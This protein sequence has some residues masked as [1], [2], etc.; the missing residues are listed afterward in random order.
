M[1]IEK[2]QNNIYTKS[3]D[4]VEA[5]LVNIISRYFNDNKEDISKNVEQIINETI[6]RV[7]IDI[8]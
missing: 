5:H 1:R 4:K 7:K 3:L 2:R 6:N 8:I